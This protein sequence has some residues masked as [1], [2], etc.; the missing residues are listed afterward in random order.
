MKGLLKSKKSGVQ[1]RLPYLIRN[2]EFCGIL[3][4]DIRDELI[5]I[6]KPAVGSLIAA[7]SSDKWYSRYDAAILLGEIGDTRAVP[8]LIRLLYDTDPNIV[9]A[10]VR[11][12]GKIGG[13]KTHKALTT[14]LHKDKRKTICQAAAVALSL[15]IT[16]KSIQNAV[17]FFVSKHDDLHLYRSHLVRIGKP[18]VPQ[19]INA[20]LSAK[21]N[22]RISA[23]E[24]LG[25]IGDHTAADALIVALRKR[26]PG[27]RSAA[28]C[29]LGTME[30]PKAVMPLI[31]AMS[32]GTEEVKSA[33]C[34]ALGSIKDKRAIPVLIRMLSDPV[35]ADE[36]KT[37]LID[38]GRACVSPL[39]D[40]IRQ[41]ADNHS[42]AK[43]IEILGY[44]RDKR[45]LPII[46]RLFEKE[47]EIVAKSCEDAFINLRS[48]MPTQTLVAL[49][50]HEHRAVREQAAYALGQRGGPHA[51]KAL[52]SKLDAP[53]YDGIVPV[54]KS[55]GLSNNRGVVTSLIRLLDHEAVA[56]R[57]HAAISLSRIGGTRARSVLQARQRDKLQSAVLPLE[58]TLN[59]KGVSYVADIIKKWDWYD[60]VKAA[61]YLGSMRS[62]KARD[63]LYVLCGDDDKHVK[64][65]AAHHLAR[66]N[67]RRALPA[68]RESLQSGNTE[69]QQWSA[70]HIAR[71]KD[72]G[73]IS[74]LSKSLKDNILST[75]Y[76]I[77]ALIRIGVPA[78]GALIDMYRSGDEFIR[79]RIVSVIAEIKDISIIASLLE[80]LHDRNAYV[81]LVAKD[82]LEDM[83]ASM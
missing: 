14:I 62:K 64:F 3:N 76:G 37:A 29:A 65:F 17:N 22:A 8:H 2:L 38:I 5:K 23:A 6:G 66:K 59:R 27:L 79:Q 51:T 18:A 26:D 83:R 60:R 80:A 40:N 46:L 44:L 61:R 55:L 1:R 47:D 52:L 50:N 56:V 43:S 77:R 72:E 41:D 34:A 73:S 9:S 75:T 74:V 33:A 67:D 24:I 21:R 57:E 25:E 39:R 13:D 35:M 45:S 12:L 78:V 19:L 28:A 30:S 82:H 70:E 49:L 54:I 15:T 48:K 36:A 68:L 16:K 71:W 20:L 7:L 32:T 11:A 10:A 4:R 58:E 53:P 31:K 81:R 69:Y 42:V 63:C